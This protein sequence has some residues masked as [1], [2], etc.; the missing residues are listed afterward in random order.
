VDDQETLRFEVQE[1]RYQR[2][3]SKAGLWVLM[4]VLFGA[5]IA[6]LGWFNLEGV[7]AFSVVS[8]GAIIAFYSLRITEMRMIL[9]AALYREINLRNNQTKE[10]EYW[11][12]LAD[13]ITRAGRG[14]Q[15]RTT[16]LSAASVAFLFT[17]IFPVPGTIEL[18]ATALMLLSFLYVFLS[19]SKSRD[20]LDRENGR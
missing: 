2:A 11:N 6:V 8:L 13:H 12:D 1:E 7:A 10:A 19:L 14:T 9:L 4:I 20:E 3:A 15:R 18:L 5:S 16:A 17:M